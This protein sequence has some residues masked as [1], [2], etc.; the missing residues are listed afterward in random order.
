MSP[1]NPTGAVY[2]PEEVEAIAWWALRHNI[3]VVTDEIYEHLTYGPHRFTSMP[4]LVPDIADQCLVLDRRERSH[5]HV[6]ATAQQVRL[7]PEPL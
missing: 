2:P 3:W 4:T 1:D 6:R 5:V 7:D